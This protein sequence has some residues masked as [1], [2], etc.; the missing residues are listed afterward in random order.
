MD[1]QENTII[2]TINQDYTI[3]EWEQPILPTVPI[4]IKTVIYKYCC[5]CENDRRPFTILL[6]I[7]WCDYCEYIM[8]YMDNMD[9]KYEDENALDYLAMSKERMKIIKEELI[10]VAL[11]PDRIRGWL[12]TRTLSS[13]W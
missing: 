8:E 3:N 10:E 13:I 1:L 2:E 5:D 9:N 7:S 12:D 6:N 11:H 4:I